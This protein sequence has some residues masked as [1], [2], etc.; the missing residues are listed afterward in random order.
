MLQR[1][2]TQLFSLSAD[3][4]MVLQ[5]FKF[6]DIKVNA[7]E[8]KCSII[9]CYGST[10]ALANGAISGSSGPAAYCS[11]CALTT[12]GVSGLSSDTCQA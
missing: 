9:D 7:D 5:R 12:S 4:N 1:S 11:T 10:L 3:G 6:S 8:T 2:N